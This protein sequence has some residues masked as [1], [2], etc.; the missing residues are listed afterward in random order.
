MT[1]RTSTFVFHSLLAP[2]LEKF[3]AEKQAC[4]Y[5]YATEGQELRRLDRFLREQG[6]VAA[7]LPRALVECWIA[8]DPNESARTQR[9]RIGLVRRLATFL[10]RQGCPA[11]LPPA[12]LTT[13]EPS[14]FVPHIFRH[15]E[16]R[17]LLEA[18]DAIPVNPRSPWRHRVLTAIFHVLYGCGLRVGEAVALRVGEVDLR[19]GVLTIRQGKFRKDRLV[20]L[21]PS[22][23]QRLRRYAD[24]LGTRS[25]DRL[26]FPA[27]HAGPYHRQTIYYA[28]RQLLWK[29][30]IPH[31]GRG[32]GPRLHDLRHT[33][34][35]HRLAMWYREGAD[36]G[37]LLPVLAT[38]LGHRS[39]TETQLYLR[40]TAD[41]FPD[42]SAR[43]EAAFGH[44]IPRRT[45]P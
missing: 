38:Y 22:L 31:G 30:R 12:Q 27:P 23:C 45:A 7:A 25:A 10:L 15:E 17:R 40:L 26:F 14:P 41:L 16:I 21:T 2:W 29:C 5:K 20:P 32:H 37:A 11:Y 28:F 39:I 35:V 4:G 34:A 36:L 19:A 6:L 33:F 1:E 44:V 24:S 18:A 3:I 9:T 42:L 13:K 8:K 43:S